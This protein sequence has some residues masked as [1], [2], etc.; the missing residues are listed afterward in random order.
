MSISTSTRVCV[1][2]FPFGATE[3]QH[4]RLSATHGEAGSVSVVRDE[5]A[6]LSL[7]F[8]WSAPAEWSIWKNGTLHGTMAGKR[9]AASPVWSCGTLPGV[10]A[11]KRPAPR[12]VG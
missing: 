8:A 12:L 9:P 7:G 5:P 11:G 10:M 3:N 6:D 2:D 1:G 4:R